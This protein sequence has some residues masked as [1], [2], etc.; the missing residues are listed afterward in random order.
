VGWSA[1]TGGYDYSDD[2]DILH[3]R[4]V[5]HAKDA[6]SAYQGTAS[7]GLAPPVGKTLHSDSPTPLV[8]AVDVT[9]SMGEWPGIIFNKLPVLYNEAKLWLPEIDI[10][11]AAIGDAY[12]DR[13]PVQICDFA[14]DRDLEQHINSIFPEGGGGGQTQ[15]SYELFAY[16]YLKHCDIPQAQKALFVYCGDEGFYEKIRRQHVQTFFGD[17]VTEDIDAYHVFGQL[18]KKFEVYNLRVQYH[19]DAADAT[20]RAQWQKAIGAQRV[21]RL[22][23][24]RRIVDCIL[25][26]TALMANEYEQFRERLTKRQTGEQVEQVINTLHPLLPGASGG[27][28]S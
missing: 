20:I 1:G 2:P 26:L 18:G 9:G 6:G 28:A 4:D 22:E 5:D 12:C 23:D 17:V 3:K 21:L 7:Q 14:K 15:E 27:S 13:Y 24:P 11:F 16:Y 10:S 19:D 25:G 8:F